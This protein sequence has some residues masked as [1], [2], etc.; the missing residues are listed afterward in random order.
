MVKSSFWALL[1]SLLLWSL[2][3]Y[4]TKQ[5]PAPSEIIRNLKTNPKQ[6]STTEPGFDFSYA[7]ENYNV[8]P[9]ADY[10]LY[11]LVVSHNN[12]GGFTD[13][14]HTSKSVDLKDACVV[15]G[16]NLMSDVYQRVKF[17]SGAWTCYFNFDNSQDAG[18]FELSQIS[19]NHLLSADPTIQ[20]HIRNL[21]IGDQIHL[22]GYLVNYANSKTPNQLRRSSTNRTD[23]GD[24]A[25]EVFYLDHL[26]VLKAG[27]PLW[28]T[29]R[30][31]TYYANYI[32]GFLFL[33][34]FIYFE[35][36]RFQRRKQPANTKVRFSQY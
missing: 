35:Q 30:T 31:I 8:D 26:K 10:E 3:L 21:N 7:G 2:S 33:V 6:Y 34:T 32:F 24:G 4:F 29:I 9:I 17:T 20:K 12:I 27:N 22:R 18:D 36:S 23:T 16:S 11:G 13:A 19:N 5:L 1:A 14:Y 25:C 28:N 15:W